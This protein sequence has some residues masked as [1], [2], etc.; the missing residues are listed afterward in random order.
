MR[1]YGIIEIKDK[2]SLGKKKKERRMNFC[3]NNLVSSSKYTEKI[4]NST[5]HKI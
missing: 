2:D 4:F 3:W 5:S 1:K